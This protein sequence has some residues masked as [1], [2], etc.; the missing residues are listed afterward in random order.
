MEFQDQPKTPSPFLVP[1]YGYWLL[2]SSTEDGDRSKTHPA[3]LS[4]LDTQKTQS[5][6][7]CLVGR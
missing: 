5:S 2:E 1:F 6:R 4:V 7:N 3:D